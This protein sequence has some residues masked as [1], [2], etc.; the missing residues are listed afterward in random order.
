[1]G[2][3]DYS[4]PTPGKDKLE[5]EWGTAQ[6]SFL[7]T[8]AEEMN[9][10]QLQRYLQI[11]E[12]VCQTEATAW[13]QSCVYWHFLLQ[14]ELLNTCLAKLQFEPLKRSLIS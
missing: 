5:G 4:T 13:L 12:S 11:R 6:P 14:K 3:L 9:Q 2:R 10:S 1:M 8:A 7:S